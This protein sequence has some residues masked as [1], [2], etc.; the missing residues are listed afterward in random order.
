MKRSWRRLSIVW[1][2]LLADLAPLRPSSK[3]Y[4]L[5]WWWLTVLRRGLD[6]SRLLVCLLRWSAKLTHNMSDIKNWKG[7]L[8]MWVIRKG[9]FIWITW[10][11]GGRMLRTRMPCMRES[12]PWLKMHVLHHSLPIHTLRQLPKLIPRA[13]SLNIVRNQYFGAGMAVSKSKHETS[14]HRWNSTLPD[15]QVA[16]DQ[17]ANV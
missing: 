4:Y 3:L 17:A 2:L 10:Q 13:V 11:N 12:M 15:Q 6:R 9:L 7:L 1:K 14:Q 16:R 5:V 8:I